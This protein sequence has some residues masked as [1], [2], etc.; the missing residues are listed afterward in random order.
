M[1]QYF[2]AL[3][4]LNYINEQAE[5]IDFIFFESKSQH[6]TNFTDLVLMIFKYFSSMTDI[7][8]L[9]IGPKRS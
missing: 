7:L 6:L 1:F 3:A 5:E 4:N 8:I 9:Q 2:V